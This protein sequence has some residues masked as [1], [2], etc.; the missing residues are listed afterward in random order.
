MMELIDCWHNSEEDRWE[1]TF[2]NEFGTSFSVVFTDDAFGVA[3]DELLASWN[4]THAY[5]IEECDC[6][7]HG[8]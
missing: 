5:D 4:E 3:I 8:K 2:Q 6:P 7:C 1:V